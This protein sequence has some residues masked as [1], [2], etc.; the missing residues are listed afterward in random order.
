MA[1]A[2]RF[3]FRA[4]YFPSASPDASPAFSALAS[5]TASVRCLASGFCLDLAGGRPRQEGAWGRVSEVGGFVLQGRPSAGPPGSE[6][7]ST[8]PLAGG[9]LWALVSTLA[10]AP[11]GPGVVITRSCC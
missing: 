2:L 8:T 6:G 7:P 5:R 9:S 10:S 3:Q 1:A 11:S 4:G